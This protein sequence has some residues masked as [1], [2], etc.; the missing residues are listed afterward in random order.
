VTAA[1]VHGD[2]VAFSRCLREAGLP[3]GIDRSESFV[4]SLE[5]IDPLSRHELYLA[6]RATLIFRRED[7]GLFDMLFDA[8]WSG[9]A[10]K[11]RRPQK[12]PR[13]P[14]HDPSTFLTSALV[15]YMSERA[16]LR[17]PEVD[18]SEQ[19][20]VASALELLVRKD[21]SRLTPDERVAIERALRD[22]RFDLVRRLTRR[23]IAARRGDQIDLRRALRMAARRDGAI[24][25]LPRRR[26]KTKRRPLVVLADISGSMELYSR[27]L[28]QFLHGITQGYAQTETFV[29]GTR[30]TRITNQLMIRS[31][32]EALD[33]VSDE[34]VDFAGGT[35]IGES[36][37]TFNR[38]YGRRVLRRGAVLLLISDGWE[39]GD[40]AVL[41]AEMRALKRR[42][43]RLV[44]LNPLLG[45]ATYEPR[46]AGMAAALA[47]VDDFLPVHDLQSLKDICSHLSRI[48]DRRDERC[49]FKEGARAAAAR[50]LE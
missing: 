10:P 26:R 48:G 21:F 23:R 45:H 29:F 16:D 39:T 32:D 44:W 28:L 30:L 38:V 31:V 42:C 20:K 19:T 49:G 24:A 8:F 47:H 17:D 50:R 34:V 4:R 40:A 36:L 1:S 9:Q 18:I 13:A 27:I 37:G 2:L 43:H 15:S 14:R 3:I 22:L 11:E 25:T 46:T 7:V 12:V 6:A 41:D 35:R 5:W 33:Q